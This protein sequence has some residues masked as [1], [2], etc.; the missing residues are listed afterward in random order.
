[1]RADR[2]VGDD[3]DRPNPTL[4]AIKPPYVAARPLPHW[5]ARRRLWLACQHPATTYRQPNTLKYGDAVQ[6][7]GKGLFA[8]FVL[9]YRA[10]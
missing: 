5:Q 7:A 2:D 1:M 9:E 3:A 8:R 6:L 10:A 4:Q